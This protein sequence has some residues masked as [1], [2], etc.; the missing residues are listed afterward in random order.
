MK[1]LILIISIIAILLITSCATDT[2]VD[3][4]VEYNKCTAICSSVLD[5][6]FVILELCR[7]E[8]K[9]KFLES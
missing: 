2:K 8:C 3:K 7:E 6:E 5:E 9:E 4:N 1:K